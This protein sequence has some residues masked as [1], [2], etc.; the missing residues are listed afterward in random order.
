LDSDKILKSNATG[1][2][3]GNYNDDNLSNANVRPVAYGL[4]ATGD[5]SGLL[6]TDAAY[7][8]LENSRNENL[9]GVVA[10]DLYP[11][12]Q[13]KIR[14]ITTTG[15]MDLPVL[16]SILNND[17]LRGIFGNW[18]VTNLGVG[19]EGNVLAPLA[20]GLGQV[21]TAAAGGPNIAAISEVALSTDGGQ[22]V[23]ITGAGFG[24]AMGTCDL[25]TVTAWAAVS[26][27]VLTAPRAAGNFDFTLTTA[28]LATTT[29]TVEFADPPE[30]PE[31]IH[32]SA[33]SPSMIG[34]TWGFAKGSTGID[35][36]RSK[37]QTTGFAR[38]AK[39]VQDNYFN[40]DDLH[41]EDT[42]YYYML[43][44]L[45]DILGIDS[46]FSDVIGVK[47]Q[48]SVPGPTPTPGGLPRATTAISF[49][50]NQG[51][52]CDLA[53]AGDFTI[54]FWV[55]GVDTHCDVLNAF[56]IAIDNGSL[57][58]QQNAQLISQRLNWSGQGWVSLFI[59]RRHDEITLGKNGA[60][61]NT[62]LAQTQ[63]S[64][65]GT[66]EIMHDEVGE[67]FDLRIYNNAV[68][69]DAYLYYYRDVTKNNGDAG[70]PIWL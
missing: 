4:A 5:L 58:L 27:T 3:A 54:M 65:S 39:N 52:E 68:S 60:V 56:D 43:K 18:D 38:I 9:T 62:F 64:F 67:L 26:V 34:L 49:A 66:L 57:Q 51:L 24:A 36:Y 11:G 19:S 10:G 15:A 53:L 44:S 6:A 28:L 33:L 13:V 40:D 35:V 14:N 55:K 59:R 22:S 41:S 32:G 69:D 7:V 61:L 16:N 20:F 47:T 30:I 29:A 21:G 42:Y 31:D 45:S 2:G 63:P 8:T 70:L 12:E 25:G 46:G 23:T 48:S 50:P 1:S 17:T 37:H